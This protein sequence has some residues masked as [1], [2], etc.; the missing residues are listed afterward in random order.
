MGSMILRDIRILLI[1]IWL[2]SAVFFS[3]AVAPTAFNVLPTR[4]LAGTVVTRTISIVNLSGFF[5]SIILLL[6]VGFGQRSNTEIAERVLL[7]VLG[8][9]TALGHWYINGQLAMLR[10]QM[11]MI[12]QLSE[13]H[14]LRI[15]FNSLHRYSVI[16]LTVAMVSAAV[17]LVLTS[18]GAKDYWKG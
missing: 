11:G 2:G 14:P 1:A 10:L 9:S 4:E 5:T 17:V 13:Q 7:I 6:T 18:R 15:E 16:A 12:D 8:A 3:F